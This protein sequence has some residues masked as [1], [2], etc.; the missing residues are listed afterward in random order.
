MFFSVKSY[1]TIDKNENKCLRGKDVS[2]KIC[3]NKPKSAVEQKICQWFFL[4]NSIRKKAKVYVKKKIS[5]Q[6]CK[7]AVKKN[8]KV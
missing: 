1:Q 3:E 2:M 6:I 7:N 4:F 5:T 8:I